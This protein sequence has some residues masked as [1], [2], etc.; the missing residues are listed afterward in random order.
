MV[1]PG[2]PVTGSLFEPS[3]LAVIVVVVEVER[4]IVVVV[5]VVIVRLVVVVVEVAC[6][7]F[8]AISQTHKS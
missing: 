5:I 7:I 3:V 6:G 4:V 8:L 1:S 2:V